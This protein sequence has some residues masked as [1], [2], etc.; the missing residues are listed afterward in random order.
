MGLRAQRTGAR[1]ESSSSRPQGQDDPLP[2]QC[3]SPQ[4]N[5]RALG[6]L[7]SPSPA[8][9]RLGAGLS[10]Q[11]SSVSTFNSAQT[12]TVLLENMSHSCPMQQTRSCPELPR[13]LSGCPWGEGAEWGSSGTEVLRPPGEGGSWEGRAELR[14]DKQ[15]P[16]AGVGS[17]ALKAQAMVTLSLG[18]QDRPQVTQCTALLG[19]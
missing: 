14:L 10:T 4:E 1:T 2:T 5:S 6:P 16:A 3:G 7:T 19:C 8:C 15:K 11:S 18:Q 17:R 9:L 13:H 12:Q